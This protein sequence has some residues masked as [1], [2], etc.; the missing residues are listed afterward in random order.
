[1]SDDSPETRPVLHV[2]LS[3]GD[4]H[5]SLALSEPVL[6]IGRCVP[7]KPAPHIATK[8]KTVSRLQAEIRWEGKNYWIA[9]A[10][11][12]SGT[13]YN[14]ERIGKGDRMPLAT[15]VTLKFG[16]TTASIRIERQSQYQ[17]FDVFLCHSSADKPQVRKMAR[18]L[19]KAGLNPWLDEDDLAA[20]VGF[21]GA[22]SDALRVVGVAA[23]VWGPNSPGRWQQREIEY[24]QRANV[25]Q[26]VRVI[27]VILAGVDGDPRWPVFMDLVQRI[28]FRKPHKDPMSQLIA[29]IRSDD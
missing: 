18:E 19:R 7:D 25:E 21:I 29:A 24:L 15:G 11:S 26:G 2:D 13:Y 28:D 1:M 5:R 23:V 9:D 3:Y 17:A 4:L 27:P 20:S 6:R 8:D 12:L 14:G 16:E 22:L 10:G